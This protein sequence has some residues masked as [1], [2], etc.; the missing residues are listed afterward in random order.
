MDAVGARSACDSCER[1]ANARSATDWRALRGRRARSRSACRRRSWA[2]R[3]A[4]A[5]RHAGLAHVADGATRTRLAG[6]DRRGAQRRGR[7]CSAQPPAQGTCLAAVCVPPARVPGPAAAPASARVW[8]FVRTR[9]CGRSRVSTQR[10]GAGRTPVLPRMPGAGH[11]RGSHNLGAGGASATDRPARRGPCVR[12][13]SARRRRQRWR[14]VR[15]GAGSTPVCHTWPASV[16]RTGARCAYKP[17]KPLQ[18]VLGNGH[19]SVKWVSQ[20]PVVYV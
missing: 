14:Y 8:C 3:G 1:A 18:A 13:H 4:G 10:P 16:R 11:A 9:N 20:L 17:V 19:F 2:R 6:P 7:A 5:E 12:N 15:S